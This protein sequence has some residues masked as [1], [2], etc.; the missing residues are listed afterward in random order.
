P[1]GAQPGREAPP[2]RAAAGPA[3][4][5]PVPTASLEPVS[6]AENLLNALPADNPSGQAPE[7][8][9]GQWKYLPLPDKDKEP[10]WHE[11]N[12]ARF[13]VS[14]DG[15]PLIGARV[16]GKKHKHE[17]THCDDWFAFR[18]SDPW[19][20]IAVSDGAGSRKFSRVGARAACEAAVTALAGNLSG[21]KLK[22]RTG[23]LIDRWNDPHDGYLMGEDLQFVR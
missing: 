23:G 15:W 14:P 22:E 17:G 7:T 18:V 16:R 13:E 20:V 19:T 10:D 6:A 2:V 9:L 8:P 1:A 11:E 5:G 4:Q 12:D 21:R 3:R